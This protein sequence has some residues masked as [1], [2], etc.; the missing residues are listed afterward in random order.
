M[1]HSRA[2]GTRPTLW[3]AL[4]MKVRDVMVSPVV[5]L[6]DTATL[7][8]A[9]ELMLAER[10]GCV[11]IVDASDRLVG[12]LTQSDF[13]AKEAGLPFSTFR[14]PQLFRQW[15]G[16]E[17]VEELYEAARDRSVTDVMVRNV[18]TVEA[19]DTIDRVVAV[20]LAHDINRVPVVE[21]DRVV[22]IVSRH[23]LLKLM[24]APTKPSL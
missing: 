6:P 4:A 1:R 24:T 3:H 5:T 23:D 17:R 18:E 19:N 20:M 16:N 7:G 8:Q 2:D 15:I 14:A 21:S 22:G 10:L 11:P 9:A 12:I 13:S